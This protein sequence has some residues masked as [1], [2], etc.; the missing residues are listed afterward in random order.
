MTDHP[1][2]VAVREIL[3]PYFHDHITVEAADEAASAAYAAVLRD[4]MQSSPPSEFWFRAIILFRAR[5]IGV[6]I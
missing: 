3:R 2:I 6:E 5:E 1:A 4:L